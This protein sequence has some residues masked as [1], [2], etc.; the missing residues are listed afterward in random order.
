[1]Q[2]VFA[3]TDY[4]WFHKDL[5]HRPGITRTLILRMTTEKKAFCP[6]PRDQTATFAII[7]YIRGVTVHK[8][9]GSVCTSALRS[10]FF[11]SSLAEMRTRGNLVRGSITFSV[12]LNSAFSTENGRMSAALKLLCR[13][14]FSW[15]EL[16]ASSSF[17]ATGSY[18]EL[19]FSFVPLMLVLFPILVD[20]NFLMPFQTSQH[21]RCATSYISDIHCSKKLKEHFFIRVWHDFNCTSLIMMWSVQ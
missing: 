18:T 2:L 8:K 15:C 11:G 12:C 5:G 21:V 16:F 20:I 14:L 17:N 7:L 19:V 6:W 3:L 1:M 10:R 9:H 4:L 13:S